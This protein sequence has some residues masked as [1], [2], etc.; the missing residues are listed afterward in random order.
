MSDE[1]FDVLNTSYSF[2]CQYNY[3]PKKETR[4]ETTE[5]ATPSLNLNEQSPKVLRTPRTDLSQSLKGNLCYYYLQDGLD[6]EAMSELKIQFEVLAA[7]HQA[8]HVLAKAV[9]RKDGGISGSD[10]ENFFGK[11]RPEK[12]KDVLVEYVYR[13]F[14]N[15]WDPPTTVGYMITQE[16]E[17]S[18]R[19]R[20]PEIQ[21]Q[22]PENKCSCQAEQDREAEILSTM[23]KLKSRRY[24]QKRLITLIGS[25][26]SNFSL[27]NKE[28]FQRILQKM[29]EDTESD[30]HTNIISRIEEAFQKLEEQGIALSDHKTP[31]SAEE[32]KL[33][34]E[35]LQYY[36]TDEGTKKKAKL[37]LRVSGNRLAV[38]K[39]LKE[40]LDLKTKKGR[41]STDTKELLSWIEIE[42]AKFTKS[43]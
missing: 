3:T 41:D 32:K 1:I 15:H 26:S 28:C 14:L 20:R 7:N 8:S 4:T 27:N 18:L 11:E 30:I 16:T 36:T 25:P 43:N 19:R 40:L 23:K 22:T 21:N 42:I 6:S 10:F 31:A 13:K 39:F 33:T 17:V 2:E 34:S 24:S 38:H 29:D 9:L 37:P 35:L 5:E 12:R